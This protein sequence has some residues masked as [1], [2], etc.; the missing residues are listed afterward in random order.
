MHY[1]HESI[2]IQILAKR[3]HHAFRVAWLQQMC[4]FLVVDLLS[5]VDPKSPHDGFVKLRTRVKIHARSL[6]RR[7]VQPKVASVYHVF[8]MLPGR[9]F[10]EHANCERFAPD[11]EYTAGIIMHTFKL[12]AQV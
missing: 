5:H 8:E 9:P 2:L 3:S 4:E 12:G 1:R 6:N 7:R 10:C 11:R